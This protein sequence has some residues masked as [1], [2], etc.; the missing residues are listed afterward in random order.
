VVCYLK[1]SWQVLLQMCLR[2]ATGLMTGKFFRK[3]ELRF[4]EEGGIGK[5]F[6]KRD[7]LFA[8]R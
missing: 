6:R 1:L 4:A 7:F 2:F 3:S 8:E 5:F